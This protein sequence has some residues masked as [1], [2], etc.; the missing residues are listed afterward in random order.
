MAP[1]QVSPLWGRIDTRTDIYGL[2]S[3]LFTLL[4]GRPP[5]MGPGLSDILADITSAKP[6]IAPAALQSDLPNALGE[7]C[8][9]CLSKAP[10]DRYQT[11]QEVCMALTEFLGAIGPRSR[12]PD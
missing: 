2:G 3:V 4:T 10:E 9:R 6:V 1:E 12:P 5:W 11:V 8:G 7:I